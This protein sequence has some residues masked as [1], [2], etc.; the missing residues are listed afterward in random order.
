MKKLP[1][2]I[3]TGGAGDG[4]NASDIFQDGTFLL[5]PNLPYKS[6]NHCMVKINQNEVMMKG[7]GVIT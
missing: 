1:C 2:F 6:R 3:L 7:S 5:G 4:E